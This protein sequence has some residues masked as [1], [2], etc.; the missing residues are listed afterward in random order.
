VIRWERANA[1][2]AAAKKRVRL[3]SLVV[4][5]EHAGMALMWSDTDSDAALKLPRLLSGLPK[6]TAKAK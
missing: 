3:T 1:R 5:H 6:A 2:V 4:R